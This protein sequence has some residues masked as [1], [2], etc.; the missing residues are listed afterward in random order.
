MDIAYFPGC[1]MHGTASDFDM[2]LKAVMPELG[3]TLHEIP[4]WNCCGASSAHG[5]SHALSIALPA[6][7]IALAA[8]NNMNTMFVPCAACYNRLVGSHYEISN[9]PDL[10][11]EIEGLIEMPYPDKM[12]F[13]HLS[14]LFDKFALEKIK[15]GVKRSL[16]DIKGAC[17]YGCLLTRPKNIITYDDHEQPQSM[18][19]VLNAMNVKSVKWGLATECCGASFSLSETDVVYK[20]TGDIIANAQKSGADFIVTSCPLCHSNL[21]MR[22]AKIMKL[23]KTK[24]IPVLYLSQLVGYML[25]FPH[26]QLGFSK[27]FTTKKL[28]EL[29]I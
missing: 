26:K 3:I 20:L 5:R 22:Q 10:K 18:E 28:K 15:S 1:S 25:G 8:K 11:K 14:Q 9:S 17:Y 29:F 2:S 23:Y 24:E 16:K 7:S 13:F 12:E 6:R 27:H 4:D 19:R 21:D